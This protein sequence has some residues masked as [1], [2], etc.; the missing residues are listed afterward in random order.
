MN[1]GTFLD[2]CLLE[3]GFSARAF[4]VAC[5]LPVG[6]LLCWACHAGGMVTY[7]IRAGNTGARRL[8][9]VVLTIPPWAALQNCTPDVAGPIPVHG[10]M[11]CYASYTFNQDTF[12]AGSLDFVASAKPAELQQAVE[13][14]PATVTPSY[15]TQ[16][17]FYQGACVMPSTPGKSVGWCFALRAG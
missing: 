10:S 6:L 14:S 1:S 16:W 2:V 8:S 7:T 4:L 3:G 15:T 11:V 17:T 13:S 12:E 5:Q 9:A